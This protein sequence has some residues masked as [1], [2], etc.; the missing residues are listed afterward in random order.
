M[1]RIQ[2]TFFISTG[3]DRGNNTGNLVFRYMEIDFI[4][5]SSCK[6]I[7]IYGVRL[8]TKFEL[9]IFKTSQNFD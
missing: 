9:I 1:C 8:T 4:Q 2:S 6:K 5:S 3:L 7:R